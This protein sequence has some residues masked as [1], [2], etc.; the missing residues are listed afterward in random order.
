L[1]VARRPFAKNG[2]RIE[3]NVSF[4]SAHPCAPSQSAPSLPPPQA[5]L[6]LLT[7]I[8]EFRQQQEALHITCMN[9]ALPLREE[10][11]PSRQGRPTETPPPDRR[12][13]F[14]VIE[15]GRSLRLCCDGL[16]ILLNLQGL[17]RGRIRLTTRSMD[18]GPMPKV[19][20]LRRGFLWSFRVGVQA[21]LR[22]HASNYRS[23]T[24]VQ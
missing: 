5:G 17:S 19:D 9:F 16:T 15:G 18:V 21:Y 12:R 11:A 2:R 10:A 6:V 23:G 14:T 7:R 24:T 22:D 8:G 13:K 20:L 4:G 1:V 3:I